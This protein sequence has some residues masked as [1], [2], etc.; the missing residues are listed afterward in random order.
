MSTNNYEFLSK[1]PKFEIIAKP[2]CKP[3]KLFDATGCD[4]IALVHQVEAWTMVCRVGGETKTISIVCRIHAWD[5]R[6]NK[7][8][9]F[10]PDDSSTNSSSVDPSNIVSEYDL[11]IDDNP[12]LFTGRRYEGI[13]KTDIYYIREEIKDSIGDEHV[14]I[15]LLDL[16]KLF[17]KE[18]E[19]CT[20]IWFQFANY[21]HFIYPEESDALKSQKVS[22]TE[23]KNHN[24]IVIYYVKEKNKDCWYDKV[25]KNSN[26]IYCG[27]MFISQKD[28]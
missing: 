5:E 8:Q 17:M 26:Q 27:E 7:L 15:L 9:C 3:F 21:L 22:C 28:F 10:D 13:N 1:I 24:E 4:C 18:F 14:S 25:N 2:Y 19:L 11:I 6:H 16:V 23:S 12:I 20:C